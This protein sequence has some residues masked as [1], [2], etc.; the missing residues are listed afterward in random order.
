MAG[1]RCLNSRFQT[2]WLSDDTDLTPRHLIVLSKRCPKIPRTWTQ[3]ATLRCK[4]R[5]NRCR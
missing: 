5:P 1:Y 2:R 3:A 4:L